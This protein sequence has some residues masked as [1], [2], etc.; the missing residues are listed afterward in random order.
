[1][2]PTWG[3]MSILNT[4]LLQG[5][6]VQNYEN[7]YHNCSYTIW[8][9]PKNWGSLLKEG[10]HDEDYSSICGYMKGRSFLETPIE[11]YLN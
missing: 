11:E 7:Q 2:I 1:M 8:K 3:H 6:L 5:S 10:S 4:G 9:F